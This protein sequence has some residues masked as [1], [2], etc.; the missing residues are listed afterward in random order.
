MSR[1]FS[2]GAIAFAMWALW[3]LLNPLTRGLMIVCIFIVLLPERR[4]L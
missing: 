1:L 4:R 2:A 3:D